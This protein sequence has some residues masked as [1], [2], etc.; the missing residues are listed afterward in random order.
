MTTT[1]KTKT[2]TTQPTFVT[3]KTLKKTIKRKNFNN[4][5]CNATTTSNKQL[6]I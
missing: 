1:A 4:N 5:K 2:R 6:N 3:T